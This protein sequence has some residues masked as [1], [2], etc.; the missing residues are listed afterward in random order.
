MSH[1]CDLEHWIARRTSPEF[2]GRLRAQISSARDML[3]RSAASRDKESAGRWLAVVGQAWVAAL[4]FQRLEVSDLACR[5][6]LTRATIGLPLA[7]T[8]A[9]YS[10]RSPAPCRPEPGK[11]W[12][13]PSQHAPPR[14]ASSQAR[15]RMAHGDAQ[16]A[17]R[18]S[19]RTTSANPT[20]TVANPAKASGAGL[21]PTTTI[22]STK[23][24]TG[25]AKASA[26]AV[27]PLMCRR[28]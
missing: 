27:A 16:W 18:S 20:N 22:A 21:S 5:A 7:A 19:A 3:H 13:R 23:A 26:T 25:S 2:I 1:S 10:A 17:S 11:Q 4:T 8:A 12:R 6:S 28:A 14:S 15:I 9:G 24:V